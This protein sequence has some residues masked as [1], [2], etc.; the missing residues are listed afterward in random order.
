VLAG[1]F[2]ALLEANAAPPVVFAF[3]AERSGASLA[4]KVAVVLADQERRWT[5][6]RPHTVEE[7]LDR[8]PDLA[9][10]REAKLELVVGEY[11]ARQQSGRPARQSTI[12]KGGL[13]LEALGTG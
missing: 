7:Y 5:S 13:Y 2:A 3:L 4:E 1:E 8:L 11:R 12:I 10:D 9:A 6:D